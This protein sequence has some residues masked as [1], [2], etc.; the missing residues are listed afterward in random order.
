VTVDLPVPAR[1]D[2]FMVQANGAPCFGVVQA[3]NVERGA[4]LVEL[5]SRIMLELRLDFVAYQIDAL[6]RMEGS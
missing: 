4:A 2:A 3:V 1:G 5:Q 6:N